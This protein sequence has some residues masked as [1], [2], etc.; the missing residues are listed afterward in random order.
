MKIEIPVVQL[1]LDYLTEDGWINQLL[2]AVVRA[3]LKSP[4]AW[5][6]VDRC[7]CFLSFANVGH[8]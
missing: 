3:R 6:H 5:L 1:V 2:M 4:G 7:R 8:P